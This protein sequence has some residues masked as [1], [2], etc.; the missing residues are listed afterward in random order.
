MLMME[1]YAIQKN[2]GEYKRVVRLIRKKL[3]KNPQGLTADFVDDLDISMDEANTVKDAL[4]AHPEW[5]D[6]KIA[7]EIDW[8]S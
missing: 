3:R 5:D 7:E 1:A 4:T 6:E 8:A 2:L